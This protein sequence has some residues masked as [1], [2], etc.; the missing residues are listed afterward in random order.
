MVARLGSGDWEIGKLQSNQNTMKT[1]QFLWWL[2]AISVLGLNV[3]TTD[4]ADGSKFAHSDSDS[5]FLHHIDLYD[6]DNRK[7]TPESDRP[8]STVKTCGRCH[9]YETISHGWHFNAFSPESL[10]GRAGEPWIWTDARTGTQLPLSYRDWKH[11]YKP[12]DAGITPWEMTLKFG[13]RIPGGGVGAAK[14]AAEKAAAAET[15]AEES[16][17]EQGEEKTPDRWAFSGTLDV[18]CMVCH[19]KPGAYD[20]NQRRDQIEEQNFT[21]AATAGLR[22]GSVDGKV[23]RIKDGSDIQDEAVKAKLPKVTYDSRRFGPD[24]TVFMDLIREPSSNACY[25]CHSNRMVDDA[26]IQKRW[27]HDEDVHLRAG[28][29]CADCHRNGIDHHIV[30]GYEDEENPSGKSVDTLS[31]AG[32]HLG[33]DSDGQ[34]DA[35]EL[36]NENVFARAGRLGSPK[37]MHAGLPPIHFE[38]MSCT[39]C[40]GGP[41]P[42]DEAL[43]IMTSLAHGLGDKGHRSGSE[44]PSIQGP[45]YTKST[46][47]K[48]RPNR[49]MWPAYWGTIS[50]GVVTP[51]NP[52]QVYD[53]TRRALRVRKNFVDELVLPK[54]SSSDLKEVLGEDR[55]K[56]P[57]DEWTDAEKSKANTLQQEKGRQ[58]FGEKVSAALEALQKELKVEQ[59]VYLSNGM[60]YAIGD[61]EKTVK[62]LELPDDQATA[63]VAWPMAHNVRPAGWSLGVAGCTECHSE[64][65]KLF[66]STVQ[67]IGPGPDVGDPIAM[68]TL[69]GVDANQRLTWNQLFSGRKSFKYIVAGSIAL[70]L[71]TLLIGVGAVASRFAGRRAQEDLY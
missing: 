11:T 32:C 66:A 22:L 48:V 55:A 63:M 29:A 71:M 44:L 16:N 50:D 36:I 49:V 28:M 10:S 54:L 70:L 47:D 42:R 7:I 24:G 45:V 27:I 62:K 23:S 25:Q 61:E 17:A 51:I 67:A 52:E 53:I 65:A 1:N 40:H 69:Q 31:C 5:R 18:D 15:D 26:G 14:E 37:P 19:A 39:A 41:V 43:R 20:F 21:W 56:T 35:D 34:V 57:V 30:R 58:L 2:A 13:G 46:D 60:V 38:K 4:A 64:S 12:T 9:D 59:A 3:Q 6:A 33:S 8:Y 68:A